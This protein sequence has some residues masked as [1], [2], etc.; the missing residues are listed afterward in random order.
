MAISMQVLELLIGEMQ[1][2]PFSGRL[3]TLGRQTSML[4]EQ[5]YKERMA[6]AFRWSGPADPRAAGFYPDVKV[7]E[8]LG[9][10]SVTALDV[11]PYEDADVIFNLNT[12][13]TPAELV[14]AFDTIIDVGAVEHVFDIAAAFRHVHQMLAPGGRFIIFTTCIHP[15]DRAFF[16][17]SPTLFHDYFAANRYQIDAIKLY[18][19]PPDRYHLDLAERVIDYTPGGLDAIQIGIDG[20]VY[21]VF[22]AVTR[23]PE[24]TCTERPT[25]GYYARLHEQ[26]A[27]R[28]RA[29]G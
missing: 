6:R 8:G 24:S 18:R 2:R 4:T 5:Y 29:A 28:R 13:D 3:L 23:L 25:Q 17:M 9:F 27:A 26:E 7:M 12:P 15:I 1:R 20:F 10:S 14:G 21:D 16:A 22:A 11:S 19:F